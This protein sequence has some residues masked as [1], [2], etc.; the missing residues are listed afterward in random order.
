MGAA[1][2]RRLAADGAAVMGIGRS[3]DLGQQVA[4]DI[5]EHG[6]TAAFRRADVGDEED[7]RAAVAATVDQFGRL[8]IVLNNAAPMGTGGKRLID[9]PTDRFEEPFRV[10]VHGPLPLARHGIPHMASGGGGSIVNISSGAA[11]RGQKYN[12]GYGPAKAA[13]EAMGRILAV[14]HG[15]EN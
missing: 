10:C 14:E 9:L 13:L 7:V 15:E 1:I 3:V 12:G 5:V 11:V 8:D 6:G 4:D 2:A